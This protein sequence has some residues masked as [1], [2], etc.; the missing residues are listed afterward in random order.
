VVARLTREALDLPRVEICPWAL[1]EG[2]MLQ[3]INRST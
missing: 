3:A 2:I 1:R